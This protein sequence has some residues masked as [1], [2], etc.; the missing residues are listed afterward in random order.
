M[1]NA[2]LPNPDLTLIENNIQPPSSIAPRTDVFRAGPSPHLHVLQEGWA[3]KYRLLSDGRRQIIAFHLPGEV[4][5]IDRIK[6]TVVPFAVL[7]LGKC[8]VARLSID[9]VRQAVDER[10][11]LR[12]LMWTPDNQ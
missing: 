3:C 12:D 5:D 2:G 8:R 4:L 1:R 6:K 9:W 11:A 7:A 10:P